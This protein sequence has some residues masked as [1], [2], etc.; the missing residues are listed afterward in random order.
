MSRRPVVTSE[1]ILHINSAERLARSRHLLGLAAMVSKRKAE[2]GAAVD[3]EAAALNGGNTHSAVHT[4]GTSTKRFKPEP[5]PSP[6]PP[7]DIK[8]EPTAAAAAATPPASDC[9]Y[10]D[11][12]NR[13]LLDF[14]AERVCSVSNSNLHVYACLVCGRYF[15]GRSPTS[16]AYNHAASAAHHLFLSLDTARVHCLPDGYEV[17]DV[18][19]RDIQYNIKPTFQPNDLHTLDTGVRRVRPAAAAPSDEGYVVGLMGLNNLK[20]TDWLNVVLQSLVRVT[21]F[22]NHFL[23][24]SYDTTDTATA[25]AALAPATS[26]APSTLSV[27]SSLQSS[28]QAVALLPSFTLLLRKLCNT[29]AFRGHVSPHELL[30]ALSVA[31]NGQF[32]IDQSTDPLH[33]L[34]FLLN[35]LDKEIKA[36]SSSGGGRVKGETIVRECFQGMVSVSTSKRKQLRSEAS[37]AD[38]EEDEK[39]MAAEEEVEEEQKLADDDDV[40]HPHNYTTTTTRTPFLY[41]SL[42]LPPMPLFQSATTQ[43]I[44]PTVPLASLLARFLSS[45]PPTFLASGERR[46]VRLLQLPRYLIL[47]YQRFQANDFF[48]EKNHTLVHFPLTALDLSPYLSPDAAASAA[49]TP[50]PTADMSVRQLLDECR[51]GS[52]RTAGLLERD[53]LVRAVERLRRPAGGKYDLLC[54]VVHDGE[55]VGGHYRAH[56]L[57]KGSGVWYE[58]DDLRVVTSE[59]MAQMVGLSEAYIQI[60]ERREEND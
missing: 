51:A 46:R 39:S 43:S 16:H 53:E 50:P 15:Q 40:A 11:T 42:S 14:D 54:N 35:R 10:L 3:G 28:A 60:Y 25:T 56:V 45:A 55:A 5:P 38:G 23:L 12:I 6:S 20:Q 37:K 34:S 27:S 21:R 26:S 52:I 58:M 17:R 44:L 30:H 22:R 49:S 33:F 24:A 19:L 4:N 31:S 29:R 13:R 2:E 59:T 9:P 8:S 47:H 7:P 1:S 32:R 36:A 57:H 18:T 48:R 41:L